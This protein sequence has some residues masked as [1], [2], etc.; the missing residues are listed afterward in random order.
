MKTNLSAVIF[1]VALM[2]CDSAPAQVGTELQHR[3]GRIWEDVQND[4]WIGSIDAWDFLTPAPLGFFPGFVGY[5]HPV[6][7]EDEALQQGYEN[8]NFH[9]FRSGCWIIGKN[10]LTPG[11]PPTNT[12]LMTD[13]EMYAS[14]LQTDTR[15]VEP[16][17]TPLAI[18]KNYAENS[19][20]DARLPEEMITATWN[21]NIG[22]TVTRRSYVWSFPG[23]QDFIVYDYTFKNTGI[24]VSTLTSLVVPAFPQQTLNGVYF[25]FHSGIS[26]STKSELN[27]ESVLWAIQ[28]GAFGW[29][30]GGHGIPYHDYYH[31][32]DGNTLVYSTNYNGGA[33]H[34]PS[35]LDPFPP[36]DIN[37]VRARFGP[38]L[39]SPAAFGWLALYASPLVKGGAERPTPK[40]DVLRV[41]SHY[42]GQ[43]RGQTL[44]M[45]FLVPKA[46]PISTFYTFATSPDTQKVLG[47]P[48]NRM[49]FYT[50][51]YGPYTLAPGDSVRFINAEIAGVMD[52]NDV[53]A[54]DPNHH[55]P[56]STLAAIRRNAALARQAVLCGLGGTVN[57]APIAAQVPSPPPPP[58]CDAL[59]FSLGL[60]TPAVAVAWGKVAETT[61]FTD[62]A[63]NPWFDGSADVDGYRVYQSQ[64]FQY[65]G[66]GVLPAFRGAAWKLVADIPRSQFSSLEYTDEHGVVKYHYLDKTVKFG[67]RYGYYVS[68]YWST[69][70]P[71]TSANG[72]TLSSLP[73]LASSDVNRSLPIT[74]APGPVNTLKVFVA[75]NPYVYGDSRRTFGSSNPYGIEFRN[76]PEKAT[77]RIYTLSGDRVR[78]IEHQPDARGSVFGS[79]PWDQR[80]DSG[81]LVA[82]G[83]YIYYVEPHVTGVSGTFTGKLMIIR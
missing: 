5:N 77:I 37:Q 28:A 31:I 35:N 11:V 69:P 33:D 32:E 27:Y 48:G 71:W 42:G 82:P 78:T 65:S 16:K 58:P 24:M 30:G 39:Q 3:R 74:P 19:G 15:G 2:L 38:E 44:A 1:I 60:D 61:T 8:C 49:N 34:L 64:D 70:R 81:L 29:G 53:V 36:K 20:Y 52:Y 22:V 47:N 26:V 79:E 66:D 56:D 54:G 10:L 62:G 21:T 25:V 55:F 4:G 40:P 50:L 75:P 63:G 43:L 46:F 6:G 80:T 67:L 9:N 83:L 23:A 7:N 51:S 57:G 18:A 76:L 73:E 12:P 72:T 59:N 14:G 45:E 41:D 13:Y 17:R 68:A